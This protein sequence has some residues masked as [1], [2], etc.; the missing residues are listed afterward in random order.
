MK[1]YHENYLGYDFQKGL[2]LLFFIGNIM[3]VVIMPKKK[4]GKVK[5]EDIKKLAKYLGM[6]EKE[7]LPTMYS[8]NPEVIVTLSTDIPYGGKLNLWD[9]PDHLRKTVKPLMTIGR[10]TAQDIASIT[11]RAR[12]ME[13]GYLNK[14]EVMGALKKERVG[15]KAYFSLIK[16][17]W[18]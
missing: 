13:S 12:A 17:R 6:A 10:A 18:I 16:E 4:D 3:A 2:N 15:R 7:G 1:I 8:N 9:L 14:L 5:E 11:K